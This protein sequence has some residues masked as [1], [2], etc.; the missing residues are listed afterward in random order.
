MKTYAL[1][2]NLALQGDMLEYIVEVKTQSG[3][4]ARLRINGKIIWSCYTHGTGHGLKKF[5][6]PHLGDKIINSKE[7]EEFMAENIEIFL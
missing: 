3:P 5:I 1:I 6:Q 7:L 4:A 2:H